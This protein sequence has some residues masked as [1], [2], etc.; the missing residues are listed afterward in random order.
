ML[1]ENMRDSFPNLSQSGLDPD[2]KRP[3]SV[4]PVTAG[5]QVIRPRDI[6]RSL[7]PHGSQTAL[8]AGAAFE[9]VPGVAL[10]GLEGEG[11]HDG[12]AEEPPGEAVAAR[13]HHAAGLLL[14]AIGE[15][16]HMTWK[17]NS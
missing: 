5:L 11:G 9:G 12:F 6:G 2:T 16:V 15:E 3:Q 10:A 7:V 14:T 17:G 8:V 4:R 13:G 1:L